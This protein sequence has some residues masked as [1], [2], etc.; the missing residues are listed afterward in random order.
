MYESIEESNINSNNTNINEN[1]LAIAGK[2]KPLY[3]TNYALC[4]SKD[5]VERCH[6]TD[7]NSYI[8]NNV[9][10]AIN[11]VAKHHLDNMNNINLWDINVSL[12]ASAITVKQ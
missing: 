10:V 8:N 4:L 9:L 2:L 3:E 7:V 5:L 1:Q 12:C 6:L 11:H